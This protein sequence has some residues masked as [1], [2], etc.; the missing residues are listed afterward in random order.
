MAEDLM[1][2]VM[3]FFSG[4]DEGDD[5]QNMLKQ[6]GKDLN[7][8]KHAKYFRIKSEEIDP[9]F[10]SFLFSVYKVIYPIK[11]FMK[12]DKK[13]AQL[14]QLTVE[15]CIDT[16]IQETIKRLDITELEQKA[17]T[18]RGEDLI[19]SIQADVD[20]LVKQFDQRHISTVN[21][22]Y[23]MA[24]ALNQLVKYNFPGLFKKFDPHFTD[25]SFLVEPKFPA[26]K[27][28]LIID[29]LG[30]FLTATQPL[31]PED[32]W[33]SLLKLLAVCEGQELVDTEQFNTM[34]KNIRDLHV[35]GIVEMMV[36]YTLKNPVWQWKH[37][38]LHETIGDIWLESKKNE[39][40]GYINKVNSAKK[41]SQINALTKEIF[42]SAD[43]TRIEN[44]NVPLNAMYRK[45][46]L[47][48]FV[49]AEGLNYLKAF[50]D[51]Y[52][53]KDIKEL[54]DILIIRGKWTNN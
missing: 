6:I 42:E 52:I 1:D 17:K 53:E 23:E 2:K 18:M 20:L 54:C 27:T 8:N 4:D 39:A 49:Y 29:Q 38:A 43:L 37:L 40:L 47:D 7:Q 32:D 15:S 26:I 28:I 35:T 13:L 19:S 11:Q 3:S 9:S 10:M 36:R 14:R 30:D 21:H 34:I 22:R 50:L 48:Y 51:D 44:Y 46:G 12:D 24:A 16:N 31:K 5:K 41:N 25:G 33:S 45:R